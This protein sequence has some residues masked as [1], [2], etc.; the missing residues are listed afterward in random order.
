MTG[1][2]SWVWTALTVVLTLIVIGAGLASD[3]PV[4]VVVVS[5]VAAAAATALFVGALRGATDRAERSSEGKP[6]GR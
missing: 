2:V 3:W 4:G 5:A 6:G 1:E